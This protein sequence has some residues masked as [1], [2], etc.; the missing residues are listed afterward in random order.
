MLVYYGFSVDSGET[1][2]LGDIRT[3]KW[4]TLRKKVGPIMFYCTIDCENK[5][6]GFIQTN[7]ETGEETQEEEMKI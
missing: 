4:L 3:Y 2:C 6:Y 5:T 7:L 1:V